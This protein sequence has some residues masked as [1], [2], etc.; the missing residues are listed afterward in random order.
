MRQR[1][2][3]RDARGDLPAPLLR[4]LHA[5]ELE[6]PARSCRSADRT[7]HACHPE[8]SGAR[9]LRSGRPTASPISSRR[10]KRSPSGI[11]RS[12]QREPRGAA[13]STVPT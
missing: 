10:S 13:R 9:D 7:D 12:R 11:W 6:C 8:N 1:R 4:L 3:R 5:A 2:A